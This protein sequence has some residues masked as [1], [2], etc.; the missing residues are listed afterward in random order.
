MLRY[1]VT[2]SVIKNNSRALEP[3]FI[4]RMS[5]RQ[6]NTQYAEREALQNDPC[7]YFK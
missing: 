5:F 4:I 2:N 3:K 6:S 1:Y 7:F